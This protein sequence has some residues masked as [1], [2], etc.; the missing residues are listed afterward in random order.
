MDPARLKII[1]DNPIEGGLDV[2]RTAFNTICPDRTPKGLE[3]LNEND[4][5]ELTLDLL[6]ALQ[7]LRVSRILPSSGSSKNLYSDLLRL[8]ASVNSNDYDLDRIK[9]LLHTVIAEKNVDALVW[10]QVYAAVAETTTPPRTIASSI[11]QT[12]WLHS[13][14]G[15]VN[16]SEYRKDVDRVLKE[17]L[18]AMYVG[19]P[20]FHDTFFGAIPELDRASELV[21]KKCLD[22][23]DPL[24]HEGW[25]DWP[26]DANQNKVLDWLSTII[27]KLDNLANK[28][29]STTT[30]PRR[31]LAKPNKP[32]QGSTAERKLDV[33][34]VNDSDAQKESGC[35]WSQILV[36]GE[37][38]SNPAADTASKSWLDLGRYAREVLAA[39][40]SRRFVLGFTLCGSLMR[41]WEFDRLGGIASQ[42]FDINQ[43]GERF[44]YTIIGFLWM[45]EECLGFDPTII[46]SEGQRYIEI[47]RNGEPERLIIDELMKRAPCVAGRAT[48][49]WKA[50]RD[51]DTRPLVIKDSWQYLERDEEGKLLQEATAE[52]VVNVARHYHHETVRIG[53]R[54]DDVKNHVRDGM[55]IKDAVNYRAENS[56]ASSR[57]SVRV[58]R[59][60]SIASRK[61][62]SS[63]ADTPLPPSKRSCST[64]PVKKQIVAAPNRVHRRIVL[65]DFGKP[66]YKASSRA[67]LLSALKACIEG[68][69]SLRSKAG[70]LQRDISINNL[71]INEDEENP[72]WPAFLIDL[73]LAIKERREAVSGARGKTGTRAFM[74][75]GVLLG[76]Q[77][78]FM[79][80]LESF[81]WV[82][83]WICIH[84][85]GPNE[86]R[87]VP[88][89]DQWNFISMAS[90]AELKKGRVSH[91]GDFIKAA[92]EDFTKCYQPLIPWVN[93][94]RKAVFPNGGRREKEDAELYT[95]MKKILQEAQEDLEVLAGV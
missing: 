74:A 91:E 94:L 31:L 23:D 70:I 85:D 25:R 79:H 48:T 90:L 37:L 1:E 3:S 58:G 28:H 27:K 19:L 84:Y 2:F 88:E 55:D 75:I 34:F 15:F 72:S 77:H 7:S 41:L 9:P 87:A 38:K 33:A 42:K 49:C 11:Q 40:D 36:P 20:R 24:F 17:E 92:E 45:N 67:S 32:I 53:G 52:G 82:L 35:H 30:L 86:G 18:G 21:F 47:E 66:I 65:R 4:L 76:E 46:S 56:M 80:D 83:F 14:A 68:H 8:N 71:L 61:R 5:Q 26:A 6:S 43:D 29:K 81:F 54:E 51:G 22:G 60:T 93:K 59:S 50:H 39:Q 62:S 95:S 16:S 89:F 10:K 13:T 73:D 78:S 64:S 57:T 12:P 44:V 69:E 63:Y